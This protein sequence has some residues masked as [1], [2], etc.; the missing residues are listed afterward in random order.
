MPYP[1]TGNGASYGLGR[2]LAFPIVANGGIQ[3]ISLG[4]HCDVASMRNILHGIGSEESPY[5]GRCTL[6]VE[7]S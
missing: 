1:T 7:G 6:W 4:F 2:V 5:L 3:E